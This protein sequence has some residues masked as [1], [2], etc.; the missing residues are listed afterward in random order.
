M[1]KVD[2]DIVQGAGQITC[3]RH[4]PAA[5]HGRICLNDYLGLSWRPRFSLFAKSFRVLGNLLVTNLI[6]GIDIVVFKE[7]LIF[8][9]CRFEG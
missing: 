1:W 6:D 5:N 3:I 9:E 2:I 4:R 8:L 7:L